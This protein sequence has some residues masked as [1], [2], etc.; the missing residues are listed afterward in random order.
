MDLSILIVNYNA[1]PFLQRCLASIEER[2]AGI[3]HEVCVVDNASTDGSRVLIASQ[4]PHVQLIANDRNLGFAAGVNRGLEKT[5]GRYVLW[6]N[7]DAEILNGGMVELL[8][9]LHDEPEV[10]IMGPQVLDPDGSI[11]LSCRSFPSYRTALFHRYSLL[12]RWLP[13]NRYSRRYLQTDWDH[14]AIREVDWVSGACLLHRRDILDNIGGLD[15]RFFMYCEDVD[16]CLQARRAGWK[17][18][19]HPGLRV[20]HHIAGSSRSSSSLMVV[21]RHRSM[22]RYYAKHFRRNP[23]KDAAVGAGIWGRC[24]WLMVREAFS[25][26]R[27]EVR[28]EESKRGIRMGWAKRPFDLL[29]SGLGLL[30]SAPLW[31]VIAL[32]IKLDDGGPVFYGQERVGKGGQRFRSWKFRSMVSD[33]DKRFGPLQASDGDSRVTR[34][35]RFLRATAL[36]ELPQLWNIF[37]GDMSFVGPRALVPEE[38]EVRSSRCEVQGSRSEEQS[39]RMSEAVPLEKIPGYEER[40]RVRPGLTGVAQVYAP[41]DIPRRHKFRL[42]LLYIKKHT[43]WLDL[44]LIALSFWIT[45]RGKWEDRGRKF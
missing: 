16:F 45:F 33:S 43:F 14:S 2:L 13:D 3:A 32:G 21:E 29:V 40:H 19:Y 20:L 44:R 18:Q 28:R 11:Q 31:V 9:Y 42:D 10:G 7:P 4:F 15:E 17:V 26:R 8:R 36:D 41:R 23:L 39:S 22:W 12:T 1:A 30:A 35:G 24:G 38:I 34:V 27:R 6:L 37:R 5:H 25:A